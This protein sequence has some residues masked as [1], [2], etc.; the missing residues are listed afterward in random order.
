MRNI[1][2]AVL[3]AGFVASPVF[4]GALTLTA[5]DPT[6]SKEAAAKYAV[7]AAHTT[8]CHSP[9]LTTITATAE[10]IVNGKRISVPL[11]VIRLSQPGYYAVAREWPN[12]GAWV[13]KMIAKNP[14]Y[15]DYAT[16]IVGPAG[17][18]PAKAKSFYHVPTEEEID[19]ALKPG[20]LE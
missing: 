18:S 16:S 1:L 8:A 14:E 20:D 3:A 12:E 15:K 6:T 19:L 7:F 4:A 17:A 11:H 2:T 10:G 13:V 9:E 5:D